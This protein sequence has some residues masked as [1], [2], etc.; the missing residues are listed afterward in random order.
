MKQKLLPGLFLISL[1][2]LS[3]ACTFH[4]DMDSGNNHKV[5][6]SGDLIEKT[7]SVDNFNKI[8]LIGEATIAITRADVQKITLKAQ[9]NILDILKHRV[10]NQTFDIGFEENTSVQSSKGVYVTIETPN[11]INDIIITG[12][13][14]VTISG[15]KQESFSATITGA[16]SINAYGLEVNNCD[17]TISGAGSC[18]T[19][20]NSKL[21]VTIAG[22]GMVHYKGNPSVNRSIA[23][24]GSVSQE[25]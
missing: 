15:N 3:S 6:G 16:G 5:R 25:E 11:I 10:N 23:G 4:T 2:F 12:A 14:K 21:N 22:A 17:I 8:N 9:Q 7:I 24:I 20:V 19:F 1:V 13:G 18:K